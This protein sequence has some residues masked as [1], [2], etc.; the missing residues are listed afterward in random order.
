MTSA[1][2][3]NRALADDRHQREHDVAEGVRATLA[4]G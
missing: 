3:L 1:Q 4:Q 2:L